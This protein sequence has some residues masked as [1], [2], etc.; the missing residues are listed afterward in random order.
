L[1]TATTFTLIELMAVLVLMSL[2]VGMTIIGFDGVTQ[3]TRLRSALGHV[4]SIDGLARTQAVC[5]GRPRLLQF[6][7]GTDRCVLKWPEPTS[8]QWNW[9]PGAPLTVGKR[10]SIQRVV[11]EETPKLGGDLPSIRIR[12]DGTSAAYAI[13]VRVGDEAAAIVIDGITGAARYVFGP[14]CDSLD[15]SDLLDSRSQDENEDL[16]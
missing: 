6:E 7:R 13:V 9:S 10:A 14:P 4:A 16:P 8:R 11:T 12:S 1:R 2:A 5:D 15:P 3:R